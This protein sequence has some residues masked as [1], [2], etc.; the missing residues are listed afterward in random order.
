MNI[1]NLKKNCNA[2]YFMIYKT[3][4]LIILRRQWVYLGEGTRNVIV[5][6]SLDVRTA[7]VK[8]TR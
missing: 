6:D 5:T 8:K 2:N 7:K 3:L 1:L 4:K